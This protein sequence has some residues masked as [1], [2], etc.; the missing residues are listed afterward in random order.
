[1]ISC[2]VPSGKIIAISVHLRKVKFVLFAV[3]AVKQEQFVLTFLNG[4]G[5]PGAVNVVSATFV[6]QV[7][8]VGVDVAPAVS[9]GA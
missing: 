3:T 9:G 6:A 7:E 5:T 2:I 1:M 8:V 4:P